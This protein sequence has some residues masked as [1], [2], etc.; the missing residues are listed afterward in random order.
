MLAV[1]AIFI[2]WA[3]LRPLSEELSDSEPAGAGPGGDDEGAGGRPAPGREQGEHGAAEA[4]ADHPGAGGS[5]V[6]ERARRCASTSG[7]DAS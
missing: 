1:G 3:L 2:A 7:T 6:L 4:A 5:G